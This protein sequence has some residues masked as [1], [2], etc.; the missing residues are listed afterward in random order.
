VQDD[1]HNRVTERLE[2]CHY[3]L[4]H[5]TVTFSL[6]E[7]DAL[8]GSEQVLIV[9]PTTPER[10]VVDQQVVATAFSDKYGGSLKIS[11]SHSSEDM[12]CWRASV[13]LS[14]DSVSDRIVL[15][16]AGSKVIMSKHVFMELRE[17]ATGDLLSAEALDIDGTLERAVISVFRR[18]MGATVVRV[19]GTHHFMC[20]S[21]KDLGALRLG[22][23]TQSTL[24][25]RGVEYKCSE[26]SESTLTE[27]VWEDGPALPANAA[28]TE[29]TATQDIS[30]L[31]EQLRQIGSFVQSLKHSDVF[32]VLGDDCAA[33]VEAM[34]YLC[35]SSL[36]NWTLSWHG[37]TVLST[38]LHRDGEPV[39][40]ICNMSGAAPEGCDPELTPVR[41][42][43]AALAI[44]RGLHTA[45]LLVVLNSLVA[46]TPIDAA[47][48]LAL[49]LS[50]NLTAEQLAACTYC[51]PP[52]PAASR[53]V[54][55]SLTSSGPSL[56]GSPATIASEPSSQ[57]S[58]PRTSD[59]AAARF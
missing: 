28:N 49:P 40:A 33:S 50:L 11:R 27:V 3:Q 22:D 47:S 38:V 16:V 42:D 48:L 54:S 45:R 30:Q 12:S 57:I 44:K 59:R 2:K 18:S 58:Y 15:E 17:L 43:L 8:Q 1:Y 5:T 19:A 4:G 7:E 14:P 13:P 41:H 35:T 10:P 26:A 6:E 53:M 23:R 37:S 55:K 32:L 31:G 20:R 56:Q 29:P 9:V 39:V 21:V 51:S 46:T 34:R 52:Q 36:G 24:L 25:V